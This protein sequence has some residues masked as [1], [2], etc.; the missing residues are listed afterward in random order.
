[1]KKNYMDFGGNGRTIILFHGFLSSLKYWAKLQP[2][3]SAAGYRVISIDM[4]GFGNAPKPSA[5]RYD[6]QDHIEYI[7]QTIE[8]LNIHKPF[9][10]IGHSMGAL[11]AARYTRTYPLRVSSLILLHPP[12]FLSEEEVRT[13][14]RKTGILYRFLLDSRYRRLGWILLKI[15]AFQH[16]SRHSRLARERSMRNVIEAAEISADLKQIATDT[17]LVLGL[18]DRPEY[19]DNVP[20]L[21]ISKSVTIVEENV[22]HHS[23]VLNPSLIQDRISGFI[24]QH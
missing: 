14:L 9:I 20:R 7:H 23:P 19:A 22:N 17:L 18:K 15:V 11:L 8:M 13:V 4:L 1:M 24:K 16:I 10:L 6:Y 3:L 21:A 5:A 2:R 12:L